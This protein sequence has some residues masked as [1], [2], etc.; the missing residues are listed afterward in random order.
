MSS[1]SSCEVTED[2]IPLITLSSGKCYC[3]KSDLGWLLLSD[4]NSIIWKASHQ[5]VLVRS[6]SALSETKLPLKS[7]QSQVKG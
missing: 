3:Y 6:A 2:G 5:D 4:T 7:I 1:I